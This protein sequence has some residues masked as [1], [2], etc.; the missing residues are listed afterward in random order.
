[1]NDIK[2]ID[3]L[4]P[5]WLL[6]TIQQSI[7]GCKQW[8]YGRV[9]SAYEDEYENYYNCMLWH[10][11]YPQMED[12]LKGLSNVIASCF[13]LELLPEGPKQLEVLRLNGTT[14]ASKQY[15]HRDCDMIADEAD[16]LTSIVWWPFDSDG[17]LRFWEGQVDINKPSRMIEYKANRAVVFPSSIP[18]AGLP[19]SDWPMRVSIN[20][21]WNI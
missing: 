18:H 6:N 16:R 19:P 9:K 14:P 1:M 13:A 11:N 21:V 12:P 4:F 3:D 20:S 2:V 5:N 7:S 10:K 15:P 8:E 17:D